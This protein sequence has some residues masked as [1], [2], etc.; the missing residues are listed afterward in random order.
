VAYRSIQDSVGLSES[1]AQV[2]C[3]AERIYWRLL[4]HTDSYGR[5]AA[6]QA[7][8]RALCY[9]LLGWIT[10]DDVAEALV[11]LGHV[12]RIQIYTHEGDLYLQI[13]DFD[14]NQPPDLLRKRGK[15]RL[16]DPPKI[17][18]VGPRAEYGALIS[19]NWSLTR[20]LQDYSALGQSRA[21][22]GEHSRE[23][24]DKNPSEVLLDKSV[25]EEP[26]PRAS[27]QNDDALL[28]ELD[29]L[30]PSASQDKRWKAAVETDP[31]RVRACLEVARSGNKPAA[32]LDDLLKRG[33]HPGKG[34]ELAKPLPPLI[35]SLETWIRN[36]GHLCS[37]ASITDEI[38]SREEKRGEQLNKAERKRLMKLAND[39]REPEPSLSEEPKAA[40]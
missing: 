32:L 36:A 7:K 13:L 26:K 21:E 9:P 28:E 24:R 33:E 12:R 2:S 30:G 31:D 16:P 34:T 29:K 22:R 3:L 10:D 35:D 1:L 6:S 27:S 15:S 25:V 38:A 23:S 4:A 14:D 20:P 19:A 11:D 37:D 40:A 18:R 17:G 8:L 39:L 5:L